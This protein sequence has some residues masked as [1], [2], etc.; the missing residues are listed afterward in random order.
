MGGGGG[1]GEGNVKEDQFEKLQQEERKK[2]EDLKTVASNTEDGRRFLFP[3]ISGLA[4]KGNPIFSKGTLNWLA[5]DKRVETVVGDLPISRHLTWV[6]RHLPLLNC[7][8]IDRGEGK[9]STIYLPS[10][11]I[12]R[13]L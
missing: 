9:A 6:L 12:G 10:R 4:Y 3:S 1:A 5:R 13:S 8:R 7:Q 11:R 2:I